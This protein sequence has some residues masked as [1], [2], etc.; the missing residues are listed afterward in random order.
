MYIT[1]YIYIFTGNRVAQL[2]FDVYIYLFKD[3]YVPSWASN[4][5]FNHKPHQKIYIVF[6]C[7]IYIREPLKSWDAVE[8][9]SRIDCKVCVIVYI[10]FLGQSRATHDALMGGYHLGKYTYMIAL[11]ESSCVCTRPQPRSTKVCRA[12]Q[13]NLSESKYCPYIYILRT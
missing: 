4:K 7:C 8:G 2:V 9:W 11:S 5:L 1:L 13:V 6:F 10:L 3:I 12:E